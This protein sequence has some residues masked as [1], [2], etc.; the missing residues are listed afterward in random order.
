MLCELGVWSDCMVA[1]VVTVAV[2]AALLAA[3]D[4]AG[5][6]S[7]A[8][9]LGV[10]A[11]T[12]RSWLRRARS[13]AQALRRLALLGV[14]TRYLGRQ[15]AALADRRV[16]GSGGDESLCPGARR[17]LSRDFAVEFVRGDGRAYG[18][19][20]NTERLAVDRVEHQG[21]AAGAVMMLL[22]L[23][24]AIRLRIRPDQTG[25]RLGRSTGDAP[26]VIVTV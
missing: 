10:P 20:F 14:W 3:S 23:P 8:A 19:M 25:K 7:V 5:A 4:G 15:E 13:N 21:L 26:N 1:V 12:V 11:A 17:G 18:R 22:L 6:G 16:P 9:Q 2:S 24:V